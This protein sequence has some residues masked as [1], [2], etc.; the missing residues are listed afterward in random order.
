MIP[1]GRSPVAQ[2]IVAE[3]ATPYYCKAIMSNMVVATLS[4][5]Q[6]VRA[7]R[8]AQSSYETM[9][10]WMLC[11]K[12]VYY[13]RSGYVG[14]AEKDFQLSPYQPTFHDWVVESSTLRG[15]NGGY[16]SPSLNPPLL[17]PGFKKVKIPNGRYYQRDGGTFIDIFN[18]SPFTL[19]IQVNGELQAVL[20]PH[21]ISLAWGSGYYLQPS[22]VVIATQNGRRVG[23][24]WQ[25]RLSVA[26]RGYNQITS[27]SLTF[28]PLSFGL[29]Q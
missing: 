18:N 16:L 19:R 27:H 3:N 17:R 15:T 29:H 13:W 2:I 12:S 23:E 7:R 25:Q 6:K 28:E 21:Q 22:V 14:Y 4:P 10:V 1:I 9:P 11:Y 26:P 5:G 24:L 8:R 20:K